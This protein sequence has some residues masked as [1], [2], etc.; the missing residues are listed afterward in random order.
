MDEKGRGVRIRRAKLFRAARARLVDVE[1]R[2][3]RLAR[4]VVDIEVA[5]RR[6]EG[7]IEADALER[8]RML[9]KEA[10]E[11]L[12]VLR[13]HQR[14]ASR[15]L[16]RLATAGEAAWDDLECAADRALTAA[17]AVADAMLERFR[18]VPR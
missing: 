16:R 3:E 8:I 12:G 13:G 9:R 18:S 15:L 2:V 14:E 5:L 7:R 1:E 10:S 4:S 17:R 6:A 11:Q